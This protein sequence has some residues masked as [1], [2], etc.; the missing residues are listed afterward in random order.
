L[1]SVCLR[2]CG[3][4][5]YIRPI[6]TNYTVTITVIREGRAESDSLVAHLLRELLSLAL[7]ILDCSGLNVSISIIA[8][9]QYDRQLTM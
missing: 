4:S 9:Q 2:V 1:R 7:N 3:A 8:S 6:P 5:T